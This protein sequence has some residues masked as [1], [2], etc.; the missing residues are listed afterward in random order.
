M[1][2]SRFGWAEGVCMRKL[3]SFLFFVTLAAMPSTVRGQSAPATDDAST[4]LSSP[5][6][7]FGTSFKLGVQGPNLQEAFIRFDLSVLPSGLQAS[8]INKATLRLFLDNVSVGGTFDVRLVTGIWSEDT[9]TYNNAPPAGLLIA[10]S[11]PVS[12]SGGR[13]F[14]LVDVTAAV[15]AWLSG[16]ANHGIVLTASPGSSIS[17]NFDSKENISTSHDPE[18]EIE[19]VSVG[20]QGPA[21]PTGA[22]GATGQTGPAG[23]AATVAVGKTNTGLPGTNALVTNAGTANAAILNFLVPQGPVGLVG[24]VGPQGPQG[25]QGATGATGAMGQQS[26][27][28]VPGIAGPMGGTGLTGPQGPQGAAGLN[29]KG[30]WNA[31]SAYNLSDAVFDSGSFWLATAANT[32]SEPSPTNTN[33]QLLAGGIVNRGAWSASNNYNVNDTVTDQGSFWLALAA[34]NNSEPSSTSTNWQQLAAAGAPGAQGPVGAQGPQ[35]TTGPTGAQGPTGLQ[36]AQGIQ[37]PIGLIGPQ[38]PP[39]PM[40]TGAALTGIPNTF[41]TS[42]TINGNLILGGTGGIQFPDGSTQTTAAASSGGGVPSGSIILGN[43]PVPPAGYTLVGPTTIGNVWAT[44]TAMPTARDGLAAAAVNGKIY[45]IGG[46]GVSL[47]RLSTVEVYDSSSN[48]WSTMASMPTARDG[49]AAA[50]VNGKIYAIGGVAA[51]NST[52]LNTVEV[53]DPSSNSW[54]TSNSTAGGLPGPVAPMPTARWALAAAVVNGKVYAIGGF[55]F[56]GNVLSAVEVYDPSSNS[57]TTSPGA[58]PPMPTPRGGLAA[59]AV[60][61]KIY[62]IGG[63]GAL[64]TVEVYDPSTNSWSTA[65]SSMPTARDVLAAAVVNG[66]IY[67]IGGITTNN[68]SLN[69]VEVY[70]PSTNSWSAVASMPTARLELAAAD[71]SGFIYAVGGF[72]SNV[73]L[74]TTEQYSPPVTVYTYMKN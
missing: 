39:G 33:W 65:F 10:G 40:P 7:N 31:A 19:V 55:D 16:T 20:P 54:T 70:D 17:V 14:V 62:A 60:N 35:G 68:Q 50:A 61:G 1:N 27:P 8:N 66:K 49:L 43:S 23:T 3:L 38:G 52:L 29:N 37:G 63:V 21:G 5:T 57:W 72:N 58:V 45:A 42:Q 46:L 24:P 15:Q 34:N 25:L 53:Y 69:T 64:N 32:S 51:D 2:S 13:D 28:G 22:Q 12:M 71:A 41:A 36:G 18:M 74:N 4:Q 48:S 44:V 59:A 30:P 6:T 9:L 67:A 11:I 26:V 56:A 47:N 73:I